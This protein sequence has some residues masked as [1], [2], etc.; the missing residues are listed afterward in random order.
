VPICDDYKTPLIKQTEL[1]M[2]YLER[3]I[4]DVEEIEDSI[5]TKRLA[6]STYINSPLVSSQKRTAETDE[7]SPAKKL[8]TCIGPVAAIEHQPQ[9]AALDQPPEPSRKEQAVPT[10]CQPKR[11][12]EFRLIRRLAEP[13][14]A[15]TLGSDQQTLMTLLQRDPELL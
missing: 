10:K 2:P 11:N 12:R 14:V 15:K 6:S 9:Q 3:S 8:R 1:N 5:N 13:Q 7:K 4:D